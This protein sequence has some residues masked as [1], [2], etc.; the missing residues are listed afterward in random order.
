[1]S[2]S[3][4][5]SV[6]RQSGLQDLAPLIEAQLPGTFS[7]P[8]QTGLPEEADALLPRVVVS[9]IHGFSHILIAPIAISLHIGYSPDWQTDEQAR[10]D[11]LHLR[12][13]SLFDVIGLLREP[14]MLFCGLTTQ[15]EMDAV[16]KDEAILALLRSKF[17]SD[18]TTSN[19]FDLT[20]RFSEVV[21]E[22]Y[23]SNT[24]Y[25][26]FR[27]WGTSSPQGV[28]L[29]AMVPLSVK[30]ARNRGIRITTDYNNRFAFNERR[31]YRTDEQ[32][33]RSVLDLALEDITTRIA[34][35]TG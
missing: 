25:E 34:E 8:R 23:Y 26:N 31:G 14:V 13:Q 28:G 12:L 32:T 15:I 3:F 27:S 35:V 1:M 16:G 30:Q 5:I 11:H 22:L 20:I 17:L 9:S 2:A 29:G 24:T 19:L 7:K 33:A 6:P 18:R 21:D 4:A 10:R